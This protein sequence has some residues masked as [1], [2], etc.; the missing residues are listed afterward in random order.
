MI[1][2]KCKQHLIIIITAFPGLINWQKF[3]SPNTKSFKDKSK[4]NTWYLIDIGSFLYCG[5]AT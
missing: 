2:T 4:K 1:I 3:L 5:P